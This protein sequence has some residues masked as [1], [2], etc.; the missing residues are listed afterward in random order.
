[1]TSYPLTPERMT[2]LDKVV[3]MPGRTLLYGFL[4]FIAVASTVM[5]FQDPLNPEF[6]NTSANPS[7]WSLEKLKSWLTDVRLP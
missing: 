4:G 2:K 7:D 5:M 6:G 3:Q 1:M